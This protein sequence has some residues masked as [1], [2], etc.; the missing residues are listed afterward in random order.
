MDGTEVQVRRPQANKPGRRAFVS[1]KRRQ[2]TKKVTV[3]TGGK[4]RTLWTGAFRPGRMHDQTA[5]K[6]EGIWDLFEQ[7]PEVKAKVDAGYLRLAR[8]FPNQVKAPPKNRARRP[9]PRNWSS[10]RRP[11]TSNPRRGSA[12]NM[13][14]PS[15]SSGGPCSAGSDAASTTTRATWPSPAGLR[16]CRREVITHPTTRRAGTPCPESRTTSYDSEVGEGCPVGQS[17]E[18]HGETGP[19]DM[20]VLARLCGQSPHQTGTTSGYRPRCL[21][22]VSPGQGRFSSDQSASASHAWLCRLLT[23]EGG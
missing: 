7:F 2:N 10:G 12:S 11:G 5:L 9:P 19:A 6:T 8:D 1:G 16:P 17:R 23:L 22:P 20:K 14:T 18:G 3:I 15:T 21:A 4:G 13:A